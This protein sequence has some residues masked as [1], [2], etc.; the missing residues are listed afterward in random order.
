MN[1]ELITVRITNTDGCFK[2]RTITVLPSDIATIVN[3]Q[4]TDATSNN[5]I[6]VF[7]SGEGIYEYALDNVFGP[8][9]ESNVFTNVDFGFHTVY[10]RDIENDCGISEEDVSVIGFPKFFTPDGNDIN[11]FWQ[12]K[13]LS[14]QF[15][16]N[17]QILIFDRY[18][19]LLAEV[20]P[21]G[22][23]WDGT[24]NGFNMPAS[25]YWFAVTL[26]D[27]RVFQSHFALIR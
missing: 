2:D 24:L 17:T 7:V 22:A 9:Q 23:G 16:P 1:L 27:G 20:D 26:Q 4:I 25:D 8:Y 21:L 5:T 6:S 18:G 11:E 14:V 15:Q 3:I 13:G 19:K 10:V 12:V